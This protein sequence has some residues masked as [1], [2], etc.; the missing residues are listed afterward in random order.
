MAKHD[1]LNLATLWLPISPSTAGIGKEM[2]EAG[3]HAKTAFDRGFSGQDWGSKAGK[4][5]SSKFIGSFTSG[6]TENSVGHAI[7]GFTNR[8]TEQTDAA[9]AAS[10]K[11]KLPGIY[12]EATRATEELRAAE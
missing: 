8:L 10:L 5:F 4:D 11:G 3:R 7:A 12:R 1:G 9:L 6:L 2:E